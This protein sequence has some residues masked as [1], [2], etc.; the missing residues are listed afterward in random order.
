MCLA[1]PAKVIELRDGGKTALVEQPG[2]RREAG[3]IIGA[4]PG[5]FVLL[6]QGLIVERIPEREA[7]EALRAVSNEKAH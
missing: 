2:V 1:A 7:K 6:Q 5:E 4:K 3:N